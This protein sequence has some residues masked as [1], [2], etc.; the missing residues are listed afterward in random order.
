MV[1]VW[2]VGQTLRYYTG[3]NKYPQDLVKVEGPAVTMY[4]L[5]ANS[6]VE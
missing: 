6:T 5:R 4:L 3:N 2:E 1:K